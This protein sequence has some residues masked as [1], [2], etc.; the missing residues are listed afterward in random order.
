MRRRARLVRIK[1]R[2]TKRIRQIINQFSRYAELSIGAQAWF[3]R[4]KRRIEHL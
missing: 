1:L 4:E 2:I 3:Q